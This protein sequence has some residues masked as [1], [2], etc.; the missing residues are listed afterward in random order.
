MFSG[1]TGKQLFQDVL[2]DWPGDEFG[3][4][5]AG[6]GDVNGDGFP[7]FAVGAAQSPSFSNLGTGYVRVFSGKTAKPLYTMAARMGEQLFGTLVAGRGD[8]TGDG[9]PDIAVTG[10]IP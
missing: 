1:K 9:R 8:V 4:S 10:H 5:V 6:V 3:F 7:D 2:G